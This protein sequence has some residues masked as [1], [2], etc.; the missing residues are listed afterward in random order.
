MPGSSAVTNLVAKRPMLNFINYVMVWSITSQMRRYKGNRDVEHAFHHSPEP[1]EGDT[2][3]VL[4]QF[5]PYRF[6]VVAERMSQVFASRYE[7]EFGLS[8]PEWRVMAVLGER[9]PRSTQQVIEATEMDRVKVSRAVIRL[10]DKALV[11]RKLHPDDQRAHLLSLTRR[12]LG[13]YHQIV[14]LARSLQAELATALKPEELRALD[15]ILVKLH[16]SAGELVP[17]PEV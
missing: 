7:R 16:A 14:P 12:G 10:A 3:L 8:I 6:S 11:A 5:L 17:Q 1:V 4:A 9:S 2:P 15:R 13:M